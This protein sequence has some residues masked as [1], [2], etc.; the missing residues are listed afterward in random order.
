MRLSFLS[1]VT[2][3]IIGFSTIIFTASCSTPTACVPGLFQITL[4]LSLIHAWRNFSASPVLNLSQ[5]YPA[6]LDRPPPASF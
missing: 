3:M 1:T 5:A 6:R 2:L 4:A